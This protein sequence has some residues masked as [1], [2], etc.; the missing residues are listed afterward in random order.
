V[1]DARDTTTPFRFVESV[2]SIGQWVSPHR[3]T[4]VNDLLW[5]GQYDDANCLYR[6]RNDFVVSSLTTATAAPID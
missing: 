2:Y 6:C 1:A 5:Y 3:L 4:D